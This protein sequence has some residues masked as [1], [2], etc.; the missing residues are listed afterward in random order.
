MKEKNSLRW[1]A[2]SCNKAW[3]SK[4]EGRYEQARSQ[5]ARMP[6]EEG[7]KGQYGLSYVL[8]TPAKLSRVGKLPVVFALSP[9]KR[10][11]RPRRAGSLEVSRQHAKAPAGEPVDVTSSALTLQERHVFRFRGVSLDF[12]AFEKSNESA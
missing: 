1:R 3:N 6:T 8:Y 11:L 7:T 2:S 9:Q 5:A 4:H 10:D 12:L